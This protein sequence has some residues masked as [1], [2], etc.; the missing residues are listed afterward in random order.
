[1]NEPDIQQAFSTNSL[2]IGLFVLFEGKEYFFGSIGRNPKGEIF[3]NTFREWDVRTTGYN[4]HISRHSDKYQHHRLGKNKLKHPF[5]LN[6]NFVSTSIGRGE[7]RYIGV[8]PRVKLFTHKFVIPDE[9]LGTVEL[10]N[11]SLVEIRIDAHKSMT[12]DSPHADV[13]QRQPFNE[14][15]AGLPNIVVTHVRYQPPQHMDN[16]GS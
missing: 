15:I 5:R 12:A 4:S 1:M 10:Q 7:A 11:K 16:Q 3:Y 9:Q 8:H 6:E 14:G 2:R 13:L